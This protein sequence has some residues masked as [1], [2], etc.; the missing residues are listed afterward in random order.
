MGGD[1]WV[2]LIVVKKISR[3]DDIDDVAI[4][5]HQFITR[6]FQ[7]RST[8]F[9]K[10]KMFFFFFKKKRKI[11]V[12]A[13]IGARIDKN[14]HSTLWPMD[15][16]ARDPSVAANWWDEITK[17]NVRFP[18]FRLILRPKIRWWPVRVWLIWFFFF[19]V[20]RNGADVCCMFDEHFELIEG[21]WT[22]NWTWM[23][24]LC[25]G[26]IIC[27]LHQVELGYVNLQM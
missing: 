13:R 20:E 6:L 12:Y 10:I 17:S 18:P 5:R 1:P 26:A 24:C 3:K 9:L 23:L 2:I 16:N 7:S 27:R 11:D 4:V 22:L 14:C 15:W 8:F 21:C 25:N 19:P